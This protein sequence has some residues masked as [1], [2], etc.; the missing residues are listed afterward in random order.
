MNVGVIWD[1]YP[2]H[3]RPMELTDPVS[4]TPVGGGAWWISAME[5]DQRKTGGKASDQPWR[6]SGLWS[7]P[8]GWFSVEV[9]RELTISVAGR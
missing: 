1:G 6:E 2:K 5:G 3:P 8:D 7:F 4:G 9:G